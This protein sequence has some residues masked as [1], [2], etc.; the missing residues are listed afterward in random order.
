MQL[1]EEELA[2]QAAAQVE[3][4]KVKLQQLELGGLVEL[5]A[6]Q[7]T[8]V[9]VGSTGNHYVVTFSDE[10]RTCQCM[11]HRWG[12]GGCCA[13]ASGVFCICVLLCCA[14]VLCCSC[15]AALLSYC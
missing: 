8:F 4:D 9:V 1:S 6:D 12:P 10:R 3:Q 14:A 15:T 2:Q 5:G 11:D 13:A 7:A